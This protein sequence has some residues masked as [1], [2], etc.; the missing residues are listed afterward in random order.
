MKGT[1]TGTNYLMVRGILI[2]DAIERLTFIEMLILMLTGRIPASLDPR[3]QMLNALLVAWS[4]HGEPPP[5]TQACRLAASCGVSFSQAAI[6]A[7]A[8]FGAQHA[9]LE[10]AAKYLQGL[11]V[12][13]NNPDVM[14]KFV[15]VTGKIPGFG[16]PLHVADPRVGPLLRLAVI[17]ELNG[18]HVQAAKTTETMLAG[19]GKEVV[20][21]LA[22]VTAALWLDMGFSAETVGVIGVVGRS[23]GLV[24]HYAE[25]KTQPAFK[26]TPPKA[27]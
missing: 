5:S 18:R 27:S 3:V 20:V 13:E 10:A 6:A 14:R 15:R 12:R 2:Q 1:E 17:L 22:G 16:H 7:F 21:N 4:D 11:V 19:F 9:P 25:Q 8:C 23:I 24:A 26:G